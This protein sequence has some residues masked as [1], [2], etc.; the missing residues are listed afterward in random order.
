MNEQ[1]LL[2]VHKKLEEINNKCITNEISL[3][4]ALLELKL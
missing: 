2:N 3:K 1:I 4:Y